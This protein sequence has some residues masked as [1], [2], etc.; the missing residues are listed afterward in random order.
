ML[1]RLPS[2]VIG[3]RKSFPCCELLANSCFQP[4]GLVV[5]GFK[6]VERRLMAQGQADVVEAFQE[7]ESAKR[8]HLEGCAE[9]PVVGDRL[10]LELNSKLIV[11]NRLCV[12]EQFG[13]LLFSEP[14]QHDA[15][16]AGV[17]EEDVGEGGRYHGAEA[18]VRER[19]GGVFAAR[20]AG[21]V[22]ARDE[23]LR[24][25]V[26]RIV[27]NERWVGIA[28]R[29]APPVEEKK[30]AVAGALDALQ[31]LL[32]Y[33]LVG[34]DVGAIQRRGQRGEC[35]KGLHQAFPPCSAGSR[36]AQLRMSTK[37]P[38]IAAAAAISGET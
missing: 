2:M 21:E 8:V 6:C 38:A 18:E 19:P 37:C 20:S 35:A 33:D 26:T 7:A 17:G 16:L 15:V 22:L 30:I 10:R 5:P 1:W 31:E 13:D 14:G 36:T 24:A 9:S 28:S 12:V 27:Q 32:R 3:L 11:W 4:A 23:N 34:I 29:C 25:L